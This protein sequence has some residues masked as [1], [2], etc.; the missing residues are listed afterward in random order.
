MLL[1]WGSPAGILTRDSALGLYNELVCWKLV[2]SKR[3]KAESGFES[4]RGKLQVSSMFACDYILHADY[5]DV[6]AFSVSYMFIKIKFCHRWT[7][8]WRHFPNPVWLLHTSTYMF[9]YIL[10]HP[11][12]MHVT[13][14]ICRSTYLGTRLFYGIHGPR[15]HL[16]ISPTFPHTPILHI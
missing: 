10:F 1:T 6:L 16:T 14:E 13:C 9:A 3:S 8:P 11:N 7:I 2:L 12:H 4:Q 15:S 5:C